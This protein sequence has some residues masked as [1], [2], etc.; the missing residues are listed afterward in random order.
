MM[1]GEVDGYGLPQEKKQRGLDPE[2]GGQFQKARRGQRLWL[3]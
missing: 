1:V 2:D 3:D